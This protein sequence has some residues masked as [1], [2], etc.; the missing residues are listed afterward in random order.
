MFRYI[1]PIGIA[2]LLA[3]AAV[4]VAPAQ[5]QSPKCGLSWDDWCRAPA[6]DICGRHKDTASCKTDPACYGMPYRGEAFAACIFDARGFAF[7]C[8][9]VGC[10]ST[11]PGHNG[12]NSPIR[13][14]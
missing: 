12:R 8:P 5:P 14:R 9:A 3:P 10:T 1:S 13:P 4:I 2:I 6:G 11:P 7:N